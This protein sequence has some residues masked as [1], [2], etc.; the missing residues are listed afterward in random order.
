M[1]ISDDER[2]A[3]IREDVSEGTSLAPTRQRFLLERLDAARA[4]RDALAAKLA[5]AEKVAA[6][7]EAYV[8]AV[9]TWEA[10]SRP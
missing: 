1:T 10:S 4:E 9:Q 5:A 2:E 7:A 8:L 6:A 3:Q